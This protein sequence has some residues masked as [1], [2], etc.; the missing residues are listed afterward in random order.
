MEKNIFYFLVKCENIQNFRF[1][2]S[3]LLE[4]PKNYTKT[5]CERRTWCGSRATNYTRITTKQMSPPSPL[6]FSSKKSE[7]PHSLPAP[8]RGGVPQFEKHCHRLTGPAWRWR[9]ASPTRLYYYYS[10][11]SGPQPVVAVVVTATACLI[12]DR[13]SC[14][15]GG[16]VRWSACLCT[17]D[18]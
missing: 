10:Y 7:Y 8:I 14:T 6:N 9:A 16:C 13:Q 15:V 1:W 18:F 5:I 11:S 4:L 12:R 2:R 3:K 17:R